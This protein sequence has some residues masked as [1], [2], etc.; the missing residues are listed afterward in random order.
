MDSVLVTVR[1]QRGER[2]RWKARAHDAHLSL[3]E[4]I[5]R[6]VEAG[7]A[8]QVRVLPVVREPDPFRAARGEAEPCR[9]GLPNC[10][11]C[12]TGVYA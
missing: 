8:P 4:F 3:S 2:E 12:Q 7:T 5:R 6:A 11:V 9:H 1:M 10:R